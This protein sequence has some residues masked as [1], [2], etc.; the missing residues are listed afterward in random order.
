MPSKMHVTLRQTVKHL[1]LC[2]YIHVFLLFVS[3]QCLRS[4]H[5]FDPCNCGSAQVI[6]FKRPHN[7]SE[8][9][10]LLKFGVN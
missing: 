10:G 6:A 1:T 2:I 5:Y 9:N 8:K 3:T 7:L 4:F